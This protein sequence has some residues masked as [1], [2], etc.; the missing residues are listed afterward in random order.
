[1]SLLERNEIEKNQKRMD[2][3]TD[4]MEQIHRST[5]ECKKVIYTIG[6]TVM[7]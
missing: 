7:W 6:E 2:D 3:A 4:S 5:N 1:M